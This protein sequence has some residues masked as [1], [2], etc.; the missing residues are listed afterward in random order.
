MVTGRLAPHDLAAEEA[1][2]AAL[3]VSDDAPFAVAGLVEPDDFFRERNGWIFAAEQ[4]L[5]ARHAPVNVIS[6]ATELEAR[7]QLAAVGGSAYLSQLTTDL[8]TAVGVEHF[9]RTVAQMATLRRLM[10]AAQTIA[11]RAWEKPRDVA[12]LIADAE[13]LIRDASGERGGDGGLEP[14]SGVLEAIYDQVLGELVEPQAHPRGIPSGWPQLDRLLAGGGFQRKMLYTVVAQ[15]SNFKSTTARTLLRNW[16]MGGRRVAL[17]TAETSK[18]ETARLVWQSMAGVD[19]HRHVA[20]Q[21]PIDTAE[22]QRV[23]EAYAQGMDHFGRFLID[24][25]HGITPAQL[26]L[27]LL[28][29]CHQQPIDVCVVDYIHRM[30]PDRERKDANMAEVY[31]EIA[32]A[33]ADLADEANVAMLVY[34]QP[35]RANTDKLRRRAGLDALMPQIDDV[36]GSSLIGKVSFGILSL[37]WPHWYVQQHI[38]RPPEDHDPNELQLSV[39]KQ[40][41]GPPFGTAFLQVELPYNRVRDP[42][43]DRYEGAEPAPWAR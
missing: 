39:L 7:G 10:T 3:L 28:R 4:A 20:E 31:G 25:T 26:R 6:V 15:T 37:F 40:Q 2:I 5:S 11:Q 24:P 17:F 9:A 32:V 8:P 34:A 43:N 29:A 14:L 22:Q 30:K 27:R 41:A 1:V 21:R 16:A 23:L 13:R 18:E 38:V 36:Y 12:G 35:N 19:F 42:E 33:L